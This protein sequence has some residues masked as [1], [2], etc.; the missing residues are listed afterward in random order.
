MADAPQPRPRTRTHKKPPG[1]FAVPFLGAP[2]TYLE[3][4]LD[5]ALRQY[6]RYGEVVG[7]NVLGVRGAYLYGAG[8]NRHILL[9][10]VDNFL[11]APIVEQVHSR[12][13]VGEGLFFIDDP[14]HKRERRLMMPAFH[15][16]RIDAYQAIMRQTTT[17]I[18]DSWQPGA[19]ID[20]AR[21]TNRLA[22]IVVGRTLF[23]MELGGAAREL[24]DAVAIVVETVSNFVLIA[25]AQLP[26]DLA[27]LG[28]G[29]TLRRAIATID[30]ILSQVIR[31]HEQSGQ[32]TGDVVSMLVAARDEDGGRLSPQQ[33]RDQLLT[34]F[35]AGH[36]TTANG[37]AWAFYLLAQHPP[38]TTRLLEELDRELGGAPPMSAADLERL[39]YLEQVA[40]EALRLYPPAPNVNRTARTEFEWQGYTIRPGDLVVYSP[41]VTQRMSTYW[42]DPDVFRP[43]RF[44]PQHGDPI[45]PYSYIPFAVGP[46]SCI[47]APFALME[48]KTVLAVALQRYRL[49][50][51]PG[52]HVEATVRTTTQPEGGILM[53]PHRQDGRVERSPAPVTGNVPGAVARR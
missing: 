33:I 20:I 50:V 1:P 15:R 39:S 18:L 49:D 16:K 3:N 44:D 27:G 31:E 26:F 41:F 2:Y 48:I 4:P 42:R 10:A 51:V 7:I 47:G 13:I 6:R 17:E 53:R 30:T 45:T 11:V 38:V 28:K 32:D 36:E 9:D 29:A 5:L 40:K 52:Q 43:S 34:L 21:Q 23:N 22:L 8:A 35:V 24:R 25:L 19:V 37:L 46:R 14:R 12:W